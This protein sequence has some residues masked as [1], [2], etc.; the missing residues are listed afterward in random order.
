MDPYYAAVRDMLRPRQAPERPPRTTDFARAVVEAGLGEPEYPDLAVVF[1]TGSP[2][3]SPVI[4]AAGV[5]QRTSTY[6]GTDILG[7]EDRSKT[8]LDLTYLPLALRHGAE[9]RS[10]A[11]VTGI[12]RDA[13][14][15]MVRWHDH[16]LGAE[17]VLRTPRLVLAAGT[18]GTLRLLLA[19]RDR[20][21]SLPDLPERLGRGFTPNGD[22]AAVVYRSPLLDDAGRGPAFG[23]F[24]RVRAQGRHRYLVG[25]VGLPLAALPLPGPVR[26]RLAQSAVLFAM[27]RDAGGATAWL[28]D[29]GL[30]TDAGRLQDPAFYA[31][32]EASMAGIADHF[33]P[34]RVLHNWPHGGSPTSLTTVHPLGG[35]AI[36]SGPDD[37]VVDHT[38]RVFGHPGL[39]VADCSLYPSSPGLPP[40]MTI[41]ALAERQAALFDDTDT[42]G[43]P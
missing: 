25:D 22:M 33:R 15:Y 39:Y 17:R 13:S 40:S 23:A 28:D 29:G 37:G 11:E 43:G 30:R 18:F 8:T 10:L 38:G 41:A 21:R 32:L 1:P 14:G 9:I 4:N 7:C 6:S 34:R 35:A 12:G 5:T 27:G 26:A 16:V 24:A 3:P 36:G 31:E 42:A 19:A 2:S 20:D